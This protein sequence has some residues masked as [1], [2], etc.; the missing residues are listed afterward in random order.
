MPICKKTHQT[1][2]R[3]ALMHIKLTDIGIV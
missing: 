3:F 1:M 2:S